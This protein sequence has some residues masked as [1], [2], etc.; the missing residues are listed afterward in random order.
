M[1]RIP[2]RKSSLSWPRPARSYGP[3]CSPGLYF[4]SYNEVATIALKKTNAVTQS[5]R[6]VIVIVGFAVALGESLSPIKLI[7]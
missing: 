1:F 6:V 4:C 2:I 5:K 7:G 3:T